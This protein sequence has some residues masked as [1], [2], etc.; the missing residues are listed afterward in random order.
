MDATETMSLIHIKILGY[1]IDDSLVF[2]VILGT[3]CFLILFFLITPSQMQ[4]WVLKSLIIWAAVTMFV[5]PLTY[6]FIEEEFTI[7]HI[8][9]MVLSV[10]ILVV[11]GFLSN[12]SLEFI[13]IAV[14]Q[15]LIWM[16]IF[17]IILDTFKE[18]LHKI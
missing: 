14:L 2:K 10:I 15:S 13:V 17:S 9:M 18:K 16:S 5:I 12:F 1:S 7:R 4:D 6:G 8:V 3:I 11:Y